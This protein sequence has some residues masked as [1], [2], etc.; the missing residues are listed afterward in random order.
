[1]ASATACQAVRG[2]RQ[3][4]LRYGLNAVVDGDKTSVHD[5]IG[6]SNDAVLRDGEGRRV[7]TRLRCTG[8]IISDLVK[9]RGQSRL[10]NRDVR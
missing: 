7:I 1:M 10:T 2:E 9:R 8:K 6:F 4:R 3:P 5:V